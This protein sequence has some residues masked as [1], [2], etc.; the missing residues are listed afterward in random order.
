MLISKI[1]LFLVK[2]WDNQ[3]SYKKNMH[4]ILMQT[5][6][7]PAFLKGGAKT[8]CQFPKQHS[9]KV[10][11]WDNQMSYQKNIHVIGLLMLTW[12]Q[13]AF[14]KAG[15]NFSLGLF[16]V[17]FEKKLTLSGGVVSVCVCVCTRVIF[18]KVCASVFTMFNV[19]HRELLLTYCVI[20]QKFQFF[21]RLAAILRS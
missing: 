13:P 6:S 12:P 10:K 9:F 5:W 7:Q 19:H 16:R 1:V 11:S 4:D 2:S 15:A 14:L 17:G 3:T 18:S 20:Y 8:K 21:G